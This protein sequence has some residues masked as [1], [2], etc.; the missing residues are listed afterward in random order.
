M[1]PGPIWI[2]KKIENCPKIKFCVCTIR[3][4]LRCMWRLKVCMHAAF[5]PYSVIVLTK[6]MGHFTSAMLFAPVGMVV[7]ILF[8]V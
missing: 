4:C 2:F 8:P 5:I 6:I 1:G 7:V 3:P